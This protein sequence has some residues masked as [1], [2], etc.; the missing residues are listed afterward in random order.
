MPDRQIYSLTRLLVSSNLRVRGHPELALIPLNLQ[1]DISNS[2]Q[3][4]T[5]HVMIDT[6]YNTVVGIQAK[7][8]ELKAILEITHPVRHFQAITVAEL[9]IQRINHNPVAGQDVL[10]DN[11]G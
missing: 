1:T 8:V 9:A 5:L 4:V 7:R 6:Y 2:G 10:P 11:Q 3:D